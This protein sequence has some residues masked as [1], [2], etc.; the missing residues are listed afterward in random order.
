MTMTTMKYN[1][2]KTAEG[3]ATTYRVAGMEQA[4]NQAICQAL[5]EAAKDV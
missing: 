5:T 1:I 3:S 4:D 2:V